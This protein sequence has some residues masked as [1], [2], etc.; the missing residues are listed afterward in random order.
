MKSTNNKK[1]KKEKD[2]KK[3]NKKFKK[4]KAK[5]KKKM[6]EKTKME[7]REI[8]REREIEKKEKD[9]NNLNI[10]KIIMN[11]PFDIKHLIESFIPFSIRIF[12]DKKTYC[13][14]Y[15]M[16]CEWIREKQNEK[17]YIQSIIKLDYFFTFK[18][19]LKT[20]Y[21]MWFHWKKY[22]YKNRVFVNYISFLF[23]F[24]SKHNAI[25]CRKIV[26]E[27]INMYSPHYKKKL[28]Q[29]QPYHPFLPF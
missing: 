5:E 17:F 19:I 9:D 8:E 4:G 10:M 21:H 6:E 12:L 7:E 27:G 2:E 28:P 24:C 1:E 23:Y 20:N 22:K 25:Q 14:N 3:K 18:Q 16:P 11:L 13:E 26:S 29:Y 15:W